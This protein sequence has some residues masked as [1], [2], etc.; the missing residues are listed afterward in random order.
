MLDSECSIALKYKGSYTKG[1]LIKVLPVAILMSLGSYC[2]Y[3]SLTLIPAGDFTAIL[4]SNIALIYVLSI[5]WLKEPTIL[6]R[7]FAVLLSVTGVVLFAYSNGF[8]GATALGIILAFCLAVLSS[9]YRVSLKV[10][11]ANASIGKS[12][13]YT[14]AMSICITL[15]VWPVVLVFHVTNFEV[16]KWPDLPW[17]NLNSIAGLGVL[18][19][20]LL[21]FGIGITY[22]IFISLG[23][24][25]G[26]PGNAIVDLIF[27]QIYFDYIKVIGALCICCGFLILLIPEERALR[28]SNSFIAVCKKRHLQ[29]DVS[30]SNNKTV[31]VI[32]ETQV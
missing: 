1:I 7:I 29:N 2:Y 25:L 27:R 32:Y 4:S 9:I 14:S 22:P 12:A 10:V 11:L 20:S 26:I 17:D 5:F 21:I 28:I 3:Y 30:V 24:L 15:T 6:I 18:F 13:L 16:I 8:E 23:V 19:N 31:T